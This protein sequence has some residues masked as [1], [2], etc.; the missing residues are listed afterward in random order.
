LTA[1]LPLVGCDEEC[2]EGVC[3]PVNGYYYDSLVTGVAYEARNEEGPTRTGTTGEDDDPGRFK[4]LNEETVG[5]CQ[6]DGTL[7]EDDFRIVHNLA[8]L[9][10]TMDTDGEHTTGIEISSD[11]AALF[12]GVSIDVDQAWAAFQTD[13]DLLGV[14]EAANN[15]SLFPDARE[16][17]TREEALRAL[18][19][20]IGL[21]TP[22][23]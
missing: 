12:E 6:V 9:L 14:L 20:G 13:P 8:V 11:V 16:L 7:P 4:Y 5:G 23:S 19:E 18:Y 15:Q 22:E 21:C 3:V 1:S 17:R 10:Q 2:A